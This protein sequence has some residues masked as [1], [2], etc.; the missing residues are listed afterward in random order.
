MNSDLSDGVIGL[1][2]RFLHI[3]VKRIFH[4][5]CWNANVSERPTVDEILDFYGSREFHRTTLETFSASNAESKNVQKLTT[6]ASKRGHLLFYFVKSFL[7]LNNHE[8]L[9]PTPFDK[10]NIEIQE[11]ATKNPGNCTFS[12]F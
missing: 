4:S 3:V 12:Y 8:P 5:R 2:T 10:P 1:L 11:T 7:A 6:T 9:H